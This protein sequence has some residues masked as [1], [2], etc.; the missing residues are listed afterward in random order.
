M[1]TEISSNRSNMKSKCWA[2][3]PSTTQSFLTSFRPV[4]E[5]DE[6]IETCLRATASPT[7]AMQVDILLKIGV[8]ESK[9]LSV[10]MQSIESVQ[11]SLFGAIPSLGTITSSLSE[12][13][14]EAPVPSEIEFMVIARQSSTDSDVSE[15]EEDDER[16]GENDLLGLQFLIEELPDDLLSVESIGSITLKHANSVTISECYSFTAS[17]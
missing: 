6:S 14:E 8:N 13:E 3:E 1:T 16:R 9:Q 10:D 11:E 4:D 2:R 5:Y 15:F 17:C 12:D 7:S